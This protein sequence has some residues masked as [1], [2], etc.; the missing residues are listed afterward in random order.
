MLIS[1]VQD[2]RVGSVLRLGTDVEVVLL[3]DDGERRSVR[4][5]FGSDADTERHERTLR[6]WRADGSLV[7]LVT[8]PGEV[9]LVDDRALLARAFAPAGPARR[10]SPRAR[11]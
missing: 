3:D 11:R 9:A 7:A 8:R 10:R 1:V 5:T 2:L 4:W 6:R